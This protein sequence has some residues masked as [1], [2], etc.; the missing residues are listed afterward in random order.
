MQIKMPGIR[1]GIM[2]CK[3]KVDRWKKGG[4]MRCKLKGWMDKGGHY[5]VQKR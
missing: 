3:C 5:N 1:E 2:R 4:I